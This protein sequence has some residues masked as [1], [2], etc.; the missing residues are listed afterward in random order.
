VNYVGN[1]LGLCC[2]FAINEKVSGKKLTENQIKQ[3]CHKG[4]TDVLKGFTTKDGRSYETSLLLDTNSFR[5][6]FPPR[7]SN[8]KTI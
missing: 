2:R 6:V 8:T 5:I 7:N 3:L 4:K 1:A